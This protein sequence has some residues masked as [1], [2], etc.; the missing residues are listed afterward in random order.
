MC[1]SACAC[2]CVRR[3]FFS[4]SLNYLFLFFRFS[5]FCLLFLFVAIISPCEIRRRLHIHTYTLTSLL[6]CCNHTLTLL[7]SQTHIYYN[8]PICQR[9]VYAIF[10]VYLEVFMWHQQFRF[11][12]F[13]LS[14]SYKVY[15]LCEPAFRFQSINFPLSLLFVWLRLSVC[16][17]VQCAVHTVN[18][19]TY[20]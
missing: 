18:A 4:F 1:L 5:L 10:I 12:G 11:S 20:L 14:L 19:C 2:T 16:V 8:E 7:H 6:H 17:C 13:Y 9:I 15:T 3:Q